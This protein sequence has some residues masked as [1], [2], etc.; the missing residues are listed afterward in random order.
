[1][2]LPCTSYHVFDEA[3]GFLAFERVDLVAGDDLQHQ[4]AVAVHVG[5]DRQQELPTGRA[6]RRYVTASVQHNERI[7]TRVQ[8]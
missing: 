5:L 1:M 6:F 4:D 3:F 2:K 7:I 8:D